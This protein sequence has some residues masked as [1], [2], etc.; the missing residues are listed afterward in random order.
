MKQRIIALFTALLMMASLM[1]SSAFAGEGNFSGNLLK[2]TTAADFRAGILTGLEVREDVGNG[3]LVLAE[4]ETEG[5]FVSA[6]YSVRAFTK[7]VASWNAGLYDGTQVEISARAR[8]GEDWS[9]WLS[10]GPYSPY[11][12]R[13]SEDNKGGALATLD[14][15]TFT[16]D[17]GTADAVQLRAQVRRDS[18]ELESP[19]LRQINLTFAGGDMTPVYAETALAQL[20]AQALNTAPAY[21]Q[22]N[23]HPSISGSICSPTTISVMLNSRD[24]GLD[25]LPEELALNIQDEG[26]GIFGNWSFCASAPGLYGFE[27]YAQYGSL[28]ILM[29]ELAQ[30]RTVGLSVKYSPNP[31]SS[32][33]YLEGAYSSTGGH[34]ITIIGYE[35][36]DGVQDEE[37]LYFYSSDS[38]SPTDSGDVKAYHR[39]KWTQLTNAWRGRMCYIIPSRTQ[40]QGAAVTGVTRVTAQLRQ[41]EID[42]TAFTLVDENGVALDMTRFTKGGGVLGYTVEGIASDMIH[43]LVATAASVVYPNPMQVTANDTFFYDLTLNDDGSVKLDVNAILAARGIAYGETRDITVYAFSDR[44]YLYIAKLEDASITA[45]AVIVTP[46]TV[47]S[48]ASAEILTYPDRIEAA[49]SANDVEGDTISLGLLLPENADPSQATVTLDGAA[50]A[51]PG[52]YMDPN[53]NRYLTVEVSSAAVSAEIDVDWTGSGTA[54]HYRIDL[55]GATRKQDLV[56]VTGNVVSVDLAAGR[57]SG[58]LQVRGDG[59]LALGEGASYAEYYSPVYDPFDWE[60]AMASLNAY[61]PGDSSVDLQI[62]AFTE[63]AQGW[64]GWYSF[65]KVGVGSASS[66]VTLEDDYVNMDTDVFTIRGSSSVANALRFQVRLVFRGSSD[67]Q[68]PAVYHAEVTYKKSAYDPSEA[69]SLSKTPVSQLPASAGK[70]I[71]AYSAYSYSGMYAWR[72]ENMILM[73]LNGQGEDL[74]FEEVGLAG[75]DQAVGY[76]N[77]TMTNFK[78]G[79]FGHRSYTQYGATATLV[80]QAIADGN[81]VG[82][83]ING[84]KVPGTNSSKTS[85]TVAYAYDTAEDGTVTFKLICPRGDKGELAAGDVYGTITAAKLDEA[86]QSSDT[87]SVRGLMYVIGAKE[88]D[89]SWTRTEAQATA[90]EGNQS[91]ALT[92]NGEALTLPAGFLA[93][94]TDFGNGGVISYTLDSE[95]VEG[96]KLAKGPFYYDITLNDDG[97]LA[98]PSRLSDALLRGETAK[99]YAIRNDGVTYTA[100]LSHAHAWDEGVVVKQ[101][102]PGVTGEKQYTCSICGG[103]KTETLASLPITPV[104][105]AP[106]EKT[107]PKDNDLPDE[108]EKSTFSDVTDQW[109]AEDVAYVAEKG[110]MTGTGD[111]KFSPNMTTSRGMIVTILWRMEGEAAAQTVPAFADVAEGAYYAKAVA[112][113]AEN[114]IVTGYSDNAFGPNDAITREQL[115]VILFRYAQ[116]KGLA[117]VDAAEHLNAFAD[118]ADVSS[119]AVQ[120]MNWAVGQGL[121]QGSNGLLLP[122]GTADRAQ[123]AAVLHRFCE[124]SK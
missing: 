123:I 85:Q 49:V 2:V 82:L 73:A 112:W 124:L 88:F 118:A 56:Q 81:V 25:L 83:F 4:G 72:F 34:L 24:A 79:L 8:Q 38:Y 75:Y 94:K 37:H 3:A 36:E 122:Q 6:V 89:S 90:A 22:G 12:S 101:P 87:S 11:I 29:Q 40:E 67:G 110:L 62:R 108:T 98:L 50:Y 96:A 114:S 105:P 30:G 64:S 53:G 78:P 1:P 60:Y 86:I 39:Y 99:L 104:G 45:D 52:T 109:F 48:D 17:S 100:V 111:G 59:S 120:A 102:A 18:A 55:I 35:Y 63:K 51:A 58:A 115:A 9:D 27:S 13:G 41:S 33:P 5:T 93:D 46:A 69:V 113:A 32:Y 119:Y 107:D 74:L 91:V 10:W 92:V 26:E 76:G 95:T 16:L 15:D 31:E 20:P 103:T 19:Q 28:E 7:M 54:A 23:R 61:V 14:Q 57:V 121:I 116:S 21:A 77:W 47:C 70:I 80:Q 65:G 68:Q 106:G 43:G 71:D 117:A 84:S 44:G 66:S 97:S 42:Q